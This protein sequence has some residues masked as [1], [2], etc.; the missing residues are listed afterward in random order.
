MPSP[1]DLKEATSDGKSAYYDGKGKAWN[2][3]PTGTA[4]HRFW[5]MGWELADTFQKE[6]TTSNTK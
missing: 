3:H 5:N 2:P 1:D 6:V 4:E